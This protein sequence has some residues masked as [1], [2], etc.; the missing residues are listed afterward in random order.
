GARPYGFPIP[1]QADANSDHGHTCYR[2]R[3][4]GQSG[5][6][7]QH[8][9]EGHK[10]AEELSLQRGMSREWSPRSAHQR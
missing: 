8:W 9:D 4:L 6:H 5:R 3:Q 1:G 7:L 2:S 10:S